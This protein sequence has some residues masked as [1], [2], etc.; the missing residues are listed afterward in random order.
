MYDLD[1]TWNVSIDSVHRADLLHSVFIAHEFIWDRNAKFE[2]FQLR[3]T[4]LF[5]VAVHVDFVVKG[6]VMF[7]DE[8]LEG[9]VLVALELVE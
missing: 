3:V 6:L 1:R 4:S 2:H 8:T 5:D 9:G 7:D